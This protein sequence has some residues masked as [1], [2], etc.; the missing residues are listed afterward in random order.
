MWSEIEGRTPRA[1]TRSTSCSGGSVR[2]E[3]RVGVAIERLQLVTSP[4]GW[5]VRY[6]RG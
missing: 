1:L 6:D 3:R 4:G 2:R 5:K